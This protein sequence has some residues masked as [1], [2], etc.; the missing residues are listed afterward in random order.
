M[1]SCLFRY[2]FS[3]LFCALAIA[4]DVAGPDAVWQPGMQ[5]MK[6][7]HAA[8]DA[9]PRPTFGDCFVDHM[10]RAGA[11]P[12]AVAFSKLIHNEGY[13]RD[14]RRIGKVGVAY[15][16]Y[17][18]R[19]NENQ[20]WLLV[21][22]SPGVVDV[23]DPKLL[24][25]D[26]WKQD[27]SYGSVTA[28]LAKAE[29]FPGE[30]GGMDDPSSLVF[31]DGS[32]EFVVSYRVL[33]GCHACSSLGYAFYGFDF[34]SGGKL[35]GVR[36]LRFVRTPMDS[37]TAAAYTPARPIQVAAGRTFTL[38]LP[39]NPTTGYSWRLLNAPRSSV[40]RLV[41]SEYRPSPSPTLGSGGEEHWTLQPVKSGSTY[42]KM[43][44]VRS[45]KDHKDEAAKEIVLS[46]IVE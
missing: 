39:S 5:F 23:D 24:P 42:L 43:D 22:G 3:T 32:Q 2:S 33:N 1:T 7:V 4:A 27:H 17:P 9:S 25:Q 18:F 34:D 6:D 14:F 12:Q 36:Y 46:V 37:G 40:V 38:V 8:C 19:A 30:R 35:Q 20:G 41:G 15:V 45:G 13:L 11:P 21:N 31:A 29:L 10:Q 16:L 44:Y 28:G 26:G